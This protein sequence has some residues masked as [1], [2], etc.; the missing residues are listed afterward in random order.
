MELIK[1][2]KEFPEE[3]MPAPLPHSRIFNKM[4]GRD[5]ALALANPEYEQAFLAEVLTKR[6]AGVRCECCDVEYD[7]SQ[8]QRCSTCH[9]TCCVSCRFS[10][11]K[12]SADQKYFKCFSCK[13][14][15]QCQKENNEFQEPHCNLCNHKGGLFLHAT[16]KPVNRSHFWKRNPKLFNTT[17]FAKQL[18]A[19]YSCAL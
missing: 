12:V 11:G 8:L 16:A 15:V 19:H 6:F 4:N 10:L 1:M 2:A 9:V 18:W 13:Y 14:K 3:P 17:L 5:R 7:G